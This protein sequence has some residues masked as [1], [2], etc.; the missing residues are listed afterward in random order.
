MRRK[1]EL[2]YSQR[3]KGGKKMMVMKKMNCFEIIRGETSVCFQT[4]KKS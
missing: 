2:A 4:E 1:E 3:D